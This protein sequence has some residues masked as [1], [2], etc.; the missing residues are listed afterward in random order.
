[1]RAVRDLSVPVG[2]APCAFPSVRSSGWGVGGYISGPLFDRLPSTEGCVRSWVG[3][4]LE[5]PVPLGGAF[6]AGQRAHLELSGSPRDGEV[7]EPFVLCVTGAS[8]DHGTYAV[9]VCGLDQ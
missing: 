9:S 8:G 7:G 3:F 1:M 6:R 2:G 4:E 5:Q